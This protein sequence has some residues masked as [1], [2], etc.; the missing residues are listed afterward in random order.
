MFRMGKNKIGKLG[1]NEKGI[2]FFWPK[3]L[4]WNTITMVQQGIR[5]DNADYF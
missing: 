1:Y 4:K 2:L 3:D 5:L